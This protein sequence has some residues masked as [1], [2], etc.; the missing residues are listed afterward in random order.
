MRCDRP[1]GCLEDVLS[2][3]CFTADLH[4]VTVPEMNETNRP[5]LPYPTLTFGIGGM[6]CD[7]CAMRVQKAL[8]AVPGVKSVSVDRVSN[9]ATITTGA[10]GVMRSVLEE[11]LRKSGYQIV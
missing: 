6:T 10:T 1:A 8:A 7:H 4:H 9:R 11:A 5:T 2:L 3:D